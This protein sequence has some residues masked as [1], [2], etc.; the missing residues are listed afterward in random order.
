V[1]LRMHNLFY[2]SEGCNRTLHLS[3]WACLLYGED[4]FTLQVQK[5]SNDV[6]ALYFPT[7]AWSLVRVRVCCSRIVG[8]MSVLC[9][10]ELVLL[11]CFLPSFFFFLL[12]DYSQ[13]CHLSM[14]LTCL[15]F[16]VAFVCACIYL[17]CRL[18][19]TIN[20]LSLS[21]TVPVFCFIFILI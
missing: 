2:W 17:A 10:V 13:S 14:N 15:E 3:K 18:P 11:Y 7:M 1:Y 21:L 8:H 20:S 9:C 16:T 12:L 6:F 4:D 5:F 19:Y